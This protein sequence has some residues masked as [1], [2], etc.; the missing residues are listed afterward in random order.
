MTIPDNCITDILYQNWQHISLRFGE[1]TCHH[2]GEVSRSPKRAMSLANHL[3]TVY[4]FVRIHLECPKPENPI[5]GSYSGWQMQ[6]N[7][8]DPNSFFITGEEMKREIIEK[9]ETKHTLGV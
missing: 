2:C 1:L 9:P 8:L 4:G 3:H 6:Y 7:T 5:E